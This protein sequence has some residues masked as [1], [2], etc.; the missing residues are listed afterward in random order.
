MITY[1]CGHVFSA[2]SGPQEI[3]QIYMALFKGMFFDESIEHV[4][5][6][7]LQIQIIMQFYLKVL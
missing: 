1:V 5:L 6:S 2:A 3:P 4:G 7:I